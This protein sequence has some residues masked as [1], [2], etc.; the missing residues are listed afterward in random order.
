MHLKTDKTTVN[1]CNF[2][3]LENIKFCVKSVDGIQWNVPN[4]QI[5]CLLSEYLFAPFACL[6][7]LV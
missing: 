4:F 1:L 3:M 2:D 5:K 7:Q 6:V